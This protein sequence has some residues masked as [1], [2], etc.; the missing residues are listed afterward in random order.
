MPVLADNTMCRVA[1]VDDEPLACEALR[2]L[3]ESIPHCQVL[4]VKHDG[5]SALDTLS[6]NP[7]DIL[8]LDIRMPGIDGIEVAR[9]MRVFNN[10]VAIIFIT[11]FEDFNYVRDAV[12]V[13]A[14]DYLLKPVD[15]AAL[16]AALE[17][18]HN[19]SLISVPV[20]SLQVRS[21]LR[22][23]P[24]S[25]HGAGIREAE[26]VLQNYCS[27]VGKDSALTYY[28]CH[29]P[30]KQSRAY[31]A[32]YEHIET[33]S[34]ANIFW[35]H[36]LHTVSLPIYAASYL[37]S[38]IRDNEVLSLLRPRCNHSGSRY[39]ATAAFD[40]AKRGYSLS[41]QQIAGHL[42][43]SAEHLS[44]LF[45]QLTEESFT[46]FSLHARLEV[47]F[48]KLRESDSPIKEIAM[49]SGFPRSHHF[50]AAFRQYFNTTPTKLR[51]AE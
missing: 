31:H 6:Q 46:Q 41:L 30:I 22:I 45:R 21:L 32:L 8:L 14:A 37:G 36:L 5:F 17:R 20:D 34:A 15:H 9:R 2:Y 48:L 18:A 10:N 11:A 3:A 28:V 19:T 1:I 26:Q 23:Y 13:R 33:V 29:H 24:D 7:P 12:R 43:V 27:W 40:A 51:I 25:H 50:T 4:W 16:C 44:R 39:V 42:A 35:R 49:T 47:A 38:E